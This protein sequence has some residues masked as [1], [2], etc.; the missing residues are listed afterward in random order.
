MLSIC[1]RNS[2]I[3]LPL[4]HIQDKIGFSYDS[5]RARCLLNL[6]VTMFDSAPA[7][8]YEPE[9]FFIRVK[10][11]IQSNE[12]ATDSFFSFLVSFIYIPIFWRC[13]LYLSP[14]LAQDSKCFIN[15]TFLYYISF[16]DFFIS[17]NT[18]LLCN[19]RKC[20]YYI[21]P[22]IKYNI[23]VHIVLFCN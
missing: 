18:I 3:S 10:P 17:W 21:F 13:M 11:D 20:I 8:A 23:L 5:I 16:L 4:A 6:S 1:S 12:T 14:E 2:K 22:L 15:I 9:R 19:G 7:F